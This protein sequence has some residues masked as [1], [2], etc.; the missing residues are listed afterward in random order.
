MLLVS[1]GYNLRD[2]KKDAQ[3]K[4]FVFHTSRL[5]VGTSLMFDEARDVLFV[6]SHGIDDVEGAF[7]MIN[8]LRR[9]RTLYIC[10]PAMIKNVR[11][12]TL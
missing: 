7:Q 12:K 3:S 4:S 5:G 1:R 2:I 11:F 10:A 9:C 6:W 8:R